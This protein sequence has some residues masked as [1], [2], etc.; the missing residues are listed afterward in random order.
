MDEL[1]CSMHEQYPDMTLV[2]VSHDLASLRAIADYVLVL[3]DGGAAFAGS[4]TEL[5]AS[6]DPYLRQF[7]R[8]EAADQ[9]LTLH[10]PPNPT[11]R[12][13]LDRWLAS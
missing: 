10:Q 7:L 5:E 3:R 11:V 1:L 2:V 13:A 6:P 4:L 9:R 8:R 12:A